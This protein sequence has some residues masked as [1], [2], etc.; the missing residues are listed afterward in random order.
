MWATH[1]AAR[2]PLRAKTADAAVRAGVRH[3]VYTSFAGASPDATFT[4]G[5]DHH[6][7]EQALAK[8]RS[9]EAERFAPRLR[10]I[11]QP[12]QAAKRDRQYRQK[13]HGGLGG[14]SQR[15]KHERE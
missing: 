3:V 9:A 8:A 14:R 2:K 13:M 4:L 15:A 10:A 1:I 12:D 5:R 11:Q 6:D 7:T